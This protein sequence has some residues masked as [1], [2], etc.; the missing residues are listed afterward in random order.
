MAILS[1]LSGVQKGELSTVTLDKAALFALP[2]IT[3]YYA[4]QAN[5]KK[6]IFYYKETTV[7]Q[8][9]VLT[10]DLS[11]ATPSTTTTFSLKAENQWEIFKIILEDFDSGFF[12]I[13]GNDLP[14]DID[15]NFV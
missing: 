1:G 6:A 5:V 9:E 2:A 11:Q 4:V 3:G 14:S 15:I 13:E 12:V 7:G 8:K 10:F